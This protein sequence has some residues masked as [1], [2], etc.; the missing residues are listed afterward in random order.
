V[1]INRF[2]Q[3]NGP[4]DVVLW[5]GVE[6]D[7]YPKITAPLSRRTRVPP[8]RDRWLLTGEVPVGMR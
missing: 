1:A 8:A 5:S 2:H 7:G 3:R 6:L 4:K